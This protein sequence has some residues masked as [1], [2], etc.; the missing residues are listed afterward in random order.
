M[1]VSLSPEVNSGVVANPEA[2]LREADERRP[3][4]GQTT[5]LGTSGRGAVRDT[6][7]VF[8]INEVGTLGTPVPHQPLPVVRRLVVPCP[9][10][11]RLAT[12]FPQQNRDFVHLQEILHLPHLH[13]NV[14]PPN[15]SPRQ[16]EVGTTTAHHSLLTSKSTARYSQESPPLTVC[17]RFNLGSTFSES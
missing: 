5:F 11:C 15:S 12:L 1:H 2:G 8:A 6:S 4:N 9:L 17:F 7:A 3:L 16:R 13:L 10:T 14:P